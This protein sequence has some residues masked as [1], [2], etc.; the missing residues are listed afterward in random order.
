MRLKPLVFL[1]AAL[2]GLTVLCLWQYNSASNLLSKESEDEEAEEQDGIKIIQQHEFEIT[3]DPTLGYVPQYRLI[4]ATDNLLKEKRARENSTDQIQGFTWIERGPY[5]DAVGPSNGNGRPGTPTPVTSGRVRAIWVDL[6]D[7]T[8]KTVWVGG[9]DGGIWKTTDVTASPASW[10]PVNDYMAN[11]AISSICQDPTNTNIMYCGTGEKTFNVDAVKG[12]G[13]WKSTDHGVTWSLLSTTTAFWNISKVICDNSGNVYVATI[14]SGS[15]LQRSANGG[16]SWTNI[17]PTTAGGGTRIS[18]MEISS[19]GR[20]HVTKGYY[21]S[22]ANAS[23]Y[24][25]TDNPSTVTPATWTLPTTSF[26]SLQYNVDLAVN[27][28]TLYALPANSSFETPVIYK[29]TDGGANWAATAS[30][31]PA[32]SGNND[33]SSGQGWYSLAIAVDPAN[34]QNVIAGGLNLYKTT[35]G[36]STWSQVS[37]WVGSTG[38]YVHAD[39]HNIVWNGNQ[40]FVGSDGGLFYSANSGTSFSDRNTNLRLK[41]FY[42][43]AIHP[44]SAN[45]FLAGAQDNGV[46]QFNGAGLTTTVEVTG[47]DGGLVAID[48]NESSYQFGTYVYNHY[49]RSINGGTNWSSITF[50]KG[51]SGSSTDFGSFINVYDYDDANNIIYGGSDGGEFFRW[52]TPQTTSSGTYYASAPGGPS[53]FSSANA[54]IISITGLSTGFV[55]AVKISPYTSNRVYFGTDAGRIVVVDN[56]NTVVSGSAGT[57]ITGASFP[58]GNVSCVNVGT[59]DNNLIASFSNYGVNN[60]WISTNG[61]TSWTGVDGNLPDVPVRWVMF[62]P[63]DNTKA[64]IATEMG[65]FQ[66]SLLNGGSTVWTQESTFPTVRTDMLDYRSSDRTIVAATHGRGLWSAIIPT[67]LPISLVNFEGHL[68]NNVVNLDWNTSAENN[69]KSFEVQKSTDGVS[70]Y[71]IGV[72]SAAGSSSTL[73]KYSLIDKQVNEA[74]YYRLKIIDRDGDYIYSDVIFIKNTNAQQY[75]WVINNPFRDYIDIRFARQAITTKLQLITMNGK[76]VAEK[77]LSA[78][79]GQQRWQLTND[80]SKGV[81]ILRV[82]ADGIVFTNKLVKD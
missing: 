29:S 51:T 66:T 49:R 41:Q 48:Q 15:G 30:S 9:V 50:M 53:S 35:N 28:N 32:A 33:L 34:D 12:G 1:S 39:Q 14:G 78:S 46:H 2:F 4:Q 64:I 62:Y 76:I 8:N 18:D 61:G 22:A 13:L 63:G 65:V 77:A 7:A 70:F 42:S 59:N 26:S 68:F 71:T 3:K 16:S 25:Y 37:V 75:V 80:L 56:A 67:V 52:T 38:T 11:L 57:N 69:S 31:P 82:I 45:Y 17:T 72:L 5:A 55:S 81:Y 10:T 19:T 20:L 47:G 54:A 27:G 6:A 24:F 23:G 74:N 60:I 79:S 44:S 43:C 21:N 73:R 40:V 58:A 36:G